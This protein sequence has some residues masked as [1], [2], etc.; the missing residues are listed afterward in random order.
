MG[1][2][3]RARAYREDCPKGGKHRMV[4]VYAGQV[5]KITKCSKCGLEKWTA[6]SRRIDFDLVRK[7]LADFKTKTEAEHSRPT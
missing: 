1:A 3:F 5:C 2:G 7:D 6:Y 4:H